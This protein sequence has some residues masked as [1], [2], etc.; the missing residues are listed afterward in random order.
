MDKITSTT[1]KT[2]VTVSDIMQGLT[3]K[4]VHPEA[5]IEVKKKQKGKSTTTI[6][7]EM[8]AKELASIMV[9]LP[10]QTDKVI[11]QKDDNAN[12]IFD[13]LFSVSGNLPFS[14]DYEYEVTINR[15]GSPASMEI[16]QK[17]AFGFGK[18]ILI[19]KTIFTKLKETQKID[20][21]AFNMVYFSEPN[22][23]NLLT[24]FKGKNELGQT[25]FETEIEKNISQLQHEQNTKQS[26]I[27]NNDDYTTKHGVLH[28]LGVNIPQLQEIRLDG[29]ETLEHYHGVIIY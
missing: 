28:G 19:Q 27:Y 9:H 2:K 21:S 10:N 1:Q 7:P 22:F 3:L 15:T 11:I 13:L 20:V 24:D 18:P 6:Y 26:T 12:L 17:V 23:E 5:L 25:V 16:T 14:D 29:A 4:G 8:S